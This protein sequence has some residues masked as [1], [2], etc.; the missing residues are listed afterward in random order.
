MTRTSDPYV[1][2]RTTLAPVSARAAPDHITCMACGYA[3]RGLA[4]DGT[5]PECGLSIR[6][7]FNRRRL[8]RM[9]RAALRR[10]DLGLQIF[11]WGH[12]WLIVAMLVGTPA[13]MTLVDVQVPA[14]STVR[15]I[16]LAALP[17]VAIVGNLVVL[18][19]AWLAAQRIDVTP[20]SARPQRART[21]VRITAGLAI[22]GITVFGCCILFEPFLPAAAG[23]VLG[24]STLL[25]TVV[26]SVSCAYLALLYHLANV[27][28]AAGRP[29]LARE[30]RVSVILLPVLTIV[31]AC[32]LIGPILAAATYLMMINHVAGLARRSRARQQRIVSRSAFP[33]TSTQASA[34]TIRPTSN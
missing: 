31:G 13:W 3:L 34:P 28:A 2:S 8:H 12:L 7:S 14:V 15:R 26:L 21:V 10:L 30:M 29:T 22:A 23:R 24:D 9:P 5:C 19:G 25:L 4:I 11:M 17:L 32:A 16:L 33:R 27:A 6:Q 20:V 18:L 1:A